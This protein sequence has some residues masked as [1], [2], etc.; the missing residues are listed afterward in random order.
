MRWRTVL[1]WLIPLLL[2]GGALYYVDTYVQTGVWIIVIFPV[3]GLV[4]GMQMSN[5]QLLKQTQEMLN[6]PVVIERHVHGHEPA[7]AS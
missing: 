1:A 3:L 7:D 4:L 6:R 2:V 5:R